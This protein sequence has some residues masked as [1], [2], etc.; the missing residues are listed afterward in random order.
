M[1]SM[2]NNPEEPLSDG[3]GPDQPIP[4]PRKRR[5]AAKKRPTIVPPPTPEL[6]T[7]GGA[8]LALRRKAHQW[9][10][11]AARVAGVD[12]SLFDPDATLESRIAWTLGVGLLIATVYTRFSGKNQ[13]ST[14]DQARAVVL[15]AAR[16]AMYVPPELICTDEATTG[17]RI[18]RVGL[19]R[20]KA[21][22]KA[23]RATVMLV[24]KASRLFRQAGEGFRLIKEHVVEEGLRAI[25]VSQ[26]ID[27]DD[28]RSWKMQLLLHGLADEMLLDAIADHCR[29]GLIGLFLKGWS[30]GAHGV[31]Y[32]AV[33]IPGAPPT[34]LGKPRTGPAVHAETV[35]LI[36]KHAG[37]LLAGMKAA[38]GARRWRAANGPYDPRS[39]VGKMTDRS[40]RRL[41][42]NVRLTGRWEYGRKRNQWSSKRDANHPELQPDSE[43]NTFLCEE[44]RILPDSTFLALQQVLSPLGRPARDRRA[45][46]TK[47]LHDL[48]TDVFHCPHCDRRY[49]ACGA[50][51]R[52][53]KCP[54]IDCQ[55]RVTV[56][57]PRAVAAVVAKLGEL[58]GQDHDLIE[59]VVTATARLDEEGD[60]QAVAEIAE[61]QRKVE[62]STRKIADLDD[63]AGDGTDE[64]R[65][66]TKAKVR[67]A[68]AERSG[69]RITLERLRRAAAGRRQVRPDEVR[70]A[71]AEFATVLAAAADGR[72]GEEEIFRAATIFRRLIGGRVTVLAGPRARRRHPEVRGEFTPA[73]LESLAEEVGIPIAATGPTPSPVS[74]WLRRPPIDGLAEEARRLHEDE[75]MTFKQ[76]GK[77]WGQS[78]SPAFRAYHRYYEM[79]GQPAPPS[80]AKH[81]RARSKR[82]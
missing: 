8:D 10:L 66:E 6:A 1:S 78:S 60:E 2:P 17:R 67:A 15:F 71:L 39:T 36:V 69:H 16:N 28:R 14:D 4:S 18:R 33:L 42:S 82:P 63:R 44:L 65:A 27:T 51:C 52:L 23:R 24:F 62:A 61:V 54:G 68:Q 59:W 49:H 9:W 26:N 75:H 35:K 57:R 47:A 20:L 70:H 40:Y 81:G 3:G 64:D 58:L 79:I 74:V 73:L 46:R 32:Q 12:L 50:E 80:T 41:F 56:D 55:H 21:I 31:G 72:L 77:L 30:V 25:S 19:D 5:E 13:H 53:M 7:E 34:N 45:A 38:E 48:V 29:E 76:I 11:E 37:W 43:V 22:L